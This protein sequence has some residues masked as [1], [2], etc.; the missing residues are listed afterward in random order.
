MI[1]LRK[2]GKREKPVS[3]KT[4]MFL[5]HGSLRSGRN[6]CGKKFVAVDARRDASAAVMRFDTYDLR[7]TPD[8]HIASHGYLSR[9]R[10]DEFDGT[11]HLK[12][13]VNQEI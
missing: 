11:S 3:K 9:Q 7:E 10:K 6:C 4:G 8:M 12:I 2:E 1:L 13:G 5:V